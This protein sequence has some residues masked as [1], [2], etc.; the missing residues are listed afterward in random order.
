MT[1][2]QSPRRRGRC[3]PNPPPLL[4]GEECTQ[5]P[6]TTTDEV[7]NHGVDV[8][9]TESR[10]K[11]PD[12]RREGIPFKYSSRAK[13]PYDVDV[14][15]PSRDGQGTTTVSSHS[16]PHSNTR[17]TTTSLDSRLQVTRPVNKSFLRPGH[18]TEDKT[19][20]GLSSYSYGHTRPVDQRT[21]V[22]QNFNVGCHHES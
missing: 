6:V 17:A 1:E 19:K 10:P 4:L 8:K 7:T 11:P 9:V 15:G 3:C 20:S 12:T 21:K 22:L 16:T 5:G 14:P 2:G 18:T 13:T